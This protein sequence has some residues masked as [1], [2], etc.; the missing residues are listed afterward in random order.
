V[1][2]SQNAG[3]GLICS[4]FVLVESNDKKG[5]RRAHHLP[6]FFLKN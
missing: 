5:D 6:L 3:R 1:R 4:D 2:V